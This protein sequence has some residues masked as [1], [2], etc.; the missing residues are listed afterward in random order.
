M[1]EAHVAAAAYGYDDAQNAAAAL[2][3]HFFGSAALHVQNLLSLVL[4]LCI[5]VMLSIMLFRISTHV[6]GT[7]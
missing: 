7:F 3:D 5:A 1:K 2:R 4:S 6:P